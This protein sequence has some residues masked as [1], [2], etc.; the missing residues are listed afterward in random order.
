ME[1]KNKYN[2]TLFTFRCSWFKHIMVS[3]L[4]WKKEPSPQIPVNQDFQSEK[5]K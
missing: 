5:L 2:I 3:N 4:R 1:Q